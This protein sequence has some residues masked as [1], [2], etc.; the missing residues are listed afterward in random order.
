[1]AIKEKEKILMVVQENIP[2][3]LKALRNWV[4]WCAEYNED[5]QQFDKIPYQ[6]DGRRASHSDFATWNTFDIV[7]KTY[8]ESNQY[9]G[10]GF[11][12]S[13]DDPYCCVDIDDIQSM[14]ELD[15]LADEIISMSYAEQ[16]P[17]GEGIHVWFKYKHNKERHKNKNQQ[18]GYEIYDN[19]R[20]I[21]FTGESLNE[22]PI[23]EG[24]FNLDSFLDKVLKREVVITQ[25]VNPLTYGKAATSEE[26][27]IRIA[28]NSK[29]GERFYKFLFGGWEENYDN[30]FSNGDMG[31]L[32]DLAFFSNRDPYMMDS[33]FRKSKLMRDK[34]DRP[35]NTSTYGWEQISKAIAECREGFV[36]SDTPKEET[37][38][39]WW[40][41]NGNGTYTFMHH[42]L[43]KEVLKSY[44]IV[45]YPTPHSDLYYY[46]KRKGIYEQDRSGRQ[47]S[48]I[49]RSFDDE[50]KSSQVREVFNYIQELSPIVNRINENYIALENGILNFTTFE[51]E[52][53]TSDI[54]VLQ[55]IP[56]KYNPNAY[57]EFVDSTLKKVTQGYEPSIMNIQEMFAC[58]LYPGVLVPK[59]HYLYGKSASNGK[60][61]ILNMIHKTFNRD[62]GNISAVTPQKLAVNTFAGASVYGKLANIVDDNP[63]SLIEDS[64][65]LKT[66]ITGG[67]IEIER[68]G[69]D[70]ETVKVNTSMIIASNHLPNFNESGNSINRRLHIIPFEHN[71]SLD[72]ECLSDVETQQRIESDS[73]REYVVKLA[74]DALKRM[75]L[76][77]NPEKLTRNEK[78]N[79]LA[80]TFAEH[81][82]PWADYFH[83]FKIDYFEDTQGTTVVKEYEQ[84]C[85]EN[86]V[87][88]LEARK[89]KETVCA[90]LDME[91]KTKKITLNGLPKAVKG[92]KKKSNTF[93]LG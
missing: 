16:S 53:F 55:K 19:K 11:V 45:R 44:P 57:D 27:I 63:D 83:E 24:G 41:A 71:F 69:K 25:Q 73:A 66:I 5:R 76:N 68:K 48:A 88:V 46:N 2:E 60:S 39:I 58:V 15:E 23:R 29:N 3:E 40:R 49:I 86:R 92:F 56:V 37:K 1:M 74:V 89:F 31:F 67:Y 10:V 59:I 20:F 8:D 77:Q 43:A 81:N 52:S 64:G 47:V 38:G 36:F 91:W 85:K 80:A 62:G 32:N 82:D 51:L 35:Q 6:I 14:D 72:A 90:R 12:L 17:S 65:L 42:I 87:P 26:E 4:L 75:L 33:I 22:L 34:W 54:F 30:N 70:A 28:L 84:W 21:S 7:Y 78:A 13:V 79:E 18:T 50:L 93:K 61:S 9:D